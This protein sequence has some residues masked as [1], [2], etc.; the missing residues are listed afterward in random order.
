MR[1]PA[2]TRSHPSGLPPSGSATRCIGWGRQ[3]EMKFPHDYPYS[4][5]SFRFL[6]KMWHPNIYDSGDVCISILHPPVDDPRSGE[7][8]SERWNPTQS[9]RYG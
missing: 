5:P 8:A 4:P 6:T 2:G 9:V 7:L 1:D 3:A